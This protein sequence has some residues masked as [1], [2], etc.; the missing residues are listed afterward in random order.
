MNADV[1][2]I[3]KIL[4]GLNYVLPDPY[5]V[6][7]A[8]NIISTREAMCFEGAIAAAYIDNK[9]FDQPPTLMGF[10]F[11]ETDKHG[12]NIGHAIHYLETNQSYL[13]IGFSRYRDLRYFLEPQKDISTIA[14]DDFL[15][16]PL[17]EQQ[18]I[19][20]GLNLIWE[21]DESN[22]GRDDGGLISTL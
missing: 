9:L 21:E 6:K 4:D 20:R 5:Y 3:K 18:E 1:L 7:S 16:R 2:H 15:S 8:I 17:H 11:S 10:L 14:G 22:N 12:K 19:M 13:A